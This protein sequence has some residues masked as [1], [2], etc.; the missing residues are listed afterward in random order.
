MKFAYRLGPAVGAALL[1]AAILLP[2]CS[3]TEDVHVTYCRELIE[4]RVGSAMELHWQ[5]SEQEIRRPEYA[6]ITLSFEA[7]QP[8]GPS[9]PMQAACFYKHDASEDTAQ[10]QGDPLSAFATVPYRLTVNDRDVSVEVL[11]AAV[12]EAALQQGRELVEQV[13]QGADQALQQVQQA[14]ER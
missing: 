3:D 5:G 8:G 4:A 6:K 12:K 11:H 9:A 1:S 14:L 13:R 10:H 2:G 7:A